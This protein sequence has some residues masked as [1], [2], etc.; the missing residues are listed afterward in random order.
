MVWPQIQA[1]HFTCGE[2]KVQLSITPEKKE[3]AVLAVS[4][5]RPCPLFHWETEAI[6][7]KLPQTPPLP[8]L[9]PVS[10]PVTWTPCVNL[11]STPST[12]TLPFI[13]SHLL[14]DNSEQ[15]LASLSQLQGSPSSA[16]S[17]TS[18]HNR[19]QFFQLYTHMHT[20]TS[21]CTHTPTPSYFFAPPSRKTSQCFLN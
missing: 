1:N 21:P 9:P 17:F 10:V 18:P 8:S 2:R 5:W 14:Q 4:C 16:G 12:G 15:F 6:R 13:L 7:R 20:C 19:L 11:N 3:P